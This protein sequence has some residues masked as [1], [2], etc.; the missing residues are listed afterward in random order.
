[1]RFIRWFFVKT[2]GLFEVD[3][4]IG[5]GRV[6]IE[7]KATEEIQVRHLK[8]LKAFQEEFPNCRLIA[9]TFDTRPRITQDVE[10]FPATEF[11]KKLWNHEII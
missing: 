7:I 4:I 5:N 11:L 2:S 10:V 3:V 1:M 6:A 9:V 8:G